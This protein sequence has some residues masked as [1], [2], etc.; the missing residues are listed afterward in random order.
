MGIEDKIA[1]LKE[2]L[3]CGNTVY[4]WKYDA[5]LRILS[6]NC[7]QES[8]LGDAFELFGGKE[9]LLEQARTTDQPMILSV[10]LGLTWGAVTE[11]D[12][13]GIQAYYLIGPIFISDVTLYD[14]KQA[15]KQ[16]RDR[17]VSATWGH[18]LI[19]CMLALPVMQ[20]CI[21]AQHTLELYYCVT[22]KRLTTS[23]LLYAEVGRSSEANAPKRDRQM[24]WQAEQHLL[25]M[26]REGDLSYRHAIERATN[27]SDG[28]P[29]QAGDPVRQAKT[30]VIVFTSLCTR[31]A[32]EGGLSPEQAYSLGDA[33]IQSVENCTTVSEVA[34]HS[35][36]MY[37]DFIERVHKCKMDNGSSKEVRSVCD[38][39]NIHLEEPIQL[40]DLAQKVGYADYYLTKKFSQEMN[41][42]IK[43][44]IKAA[45]IERAKLLLAS[46]NL[47]IQ[48]IAER[49]QYCTRGYFSS[50]FRQVTG[51]TPAEYRAEQ[52]RV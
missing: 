3:L 23:D 36:T 12:D 10:A 26:V 15:L 22:G 28:V 35:Y 13:V 31:A 21:L 25:H 14:M 49:L 4:T 52:K 41:M 30:S 44:Y 40:K 20:H 33:Y 47:S 39:I 6:S 34:G 42:S 17:Q 5:D 43:E 29:L 24:T 50:V 37:A 9:I 7:P 38:Y 2:L 18:E 46:S 32:I 27:I 8:L 19:D 51:Q 48:D 11:R 1:L 45:R 16:Y